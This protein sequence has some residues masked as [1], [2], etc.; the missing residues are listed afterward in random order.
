MELRDI[1]Y[2]SMVAKHGNLGR[3]AEALGL[4]QSALSKSLR[5]LEQE[6]RAKL[7][8]R[9]PKGV[10]LTPEGRTLLSRV[11]RLRLMLDDV[12]REVSDVKQ[13][14]VGHVRIG[15]GSGFSVHLLPLA[16]TA[17]AKVA[18][19]ITVAIKDLSQDESIQLVRNGEA[20]LAVIAQRDY[21]EQD[22]VQEHLYDDQYAV[23]ASPDHRLAAKR[24]LTLADLTQE[25]WTVAE[26]ATAIRRRLK[27]VFENHGLPPPRV[28]LETGNPVM[29]LALV[30]SS[31]V[32]AYTWLSVVRHFNSNMRLTELRVR[33]LASAFRVGVIHRKDGYLSPAALRFLEVLKSTAREIAKN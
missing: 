17:L 10:E 26:P 27:Q 29:R 23:C 33:E 21:L 19:G 12:A 11:D 24:S 1:E 9:T 7:V 14:V 3:A 20:D 30:A 31:D 16:C 32:L 5:R 8:R 22:V 13:G 28:T 2:F 4:S 18:P 25:R 6:L 15:S